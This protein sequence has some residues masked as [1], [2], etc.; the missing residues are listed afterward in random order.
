MN[1]LD[2]PSFIG[3]LARAPAPSSMT[4]TCENVVGDTG[5]EPVTSSV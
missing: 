1:D 5:I 4:L 3:A 2:G